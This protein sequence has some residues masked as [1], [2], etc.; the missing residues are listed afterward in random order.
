MAIAGNFLAA[1]APYEDNDTSSLGTDDELGFDNGAVYVYSLLGGTWSFHT[2]LKASTTNAGDNLGYSLALSEATLVVGA[3][4]DFG[5]GRCAVF[6]FDGTLWAEQAI[7]AG[8]N[9]TFNDSFGTSVALSGNIAVVGAPYED[10]DTAGVINGVSDDIGAAYVFTRTGGTW[11]EQAILKAPNA[12]IGDYFGESVA[13]SGN[14]VLV[15]AQ[16]EDSA[17][18]GTENPSFTNSGAAYL[19]SRIG[20]VWSHRRLLKGSNSALSTRFGFAV[21]MAGDTSI[22]GAVGEDSS[23]G[24]AYTFLDTGD[25]PTLT[26]A[27]RKTLRV[28]KSKSSH[29]VRGTADDVDGNLSLIEVKD[30]RPKGVKQFRRAAGTTKWS[31]RVPLRTGRNLILARATDATDFR[32][33]ISRL[34]VI[35][36]SR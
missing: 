9:S 34:T 27:G 2:Y 6:F 10:T 26:I 15:G 29:T 36:R 13:V 28:N 22:V 17:P 35:R 16:M 1:G 32:S 11:A 33:A 5:K 23:A 25:A 18:D 3:P 19:Y 12:G 20:N 31:Y 14:R 30:A 24:A 8:S 7:L 4:V 21:A